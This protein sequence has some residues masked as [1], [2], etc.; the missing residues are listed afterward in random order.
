MASAGGF[1]EALDT[2]EDASEIEDPTAQRLRSYLDRLNRVAT[3]A[4]LRSL[5]TN[6]PTIDFHRLNSPLFDGLYALIHLKLPGNPTEKK[7]VEEKKPTEEKPM[8]SPEPVPQ[9]KKA[10]TEAER[11]DARREKREADIGK[12]PP[13]T[14][15]MAGLVLLKVLRESPTP[16]KY[17]PALEYLLSKN[18]SSAS[19]GSELY[20]QYLRVAYYSPTLFEHL[21]TKHIK[22]CDEATVRFVLCYSSYTVFQIAT[23][24]IIDTTAVFSWLLQARP[25]SCPDWLPKVEIALK[26]G[27]PYELEPLSVRI[28]QYPLEF[29]Q[30]LFGAVHNPKIPGT[31]P[32][33]LDPNTEGLLARICGSLNFEVIKLFIAQGAQVHTTPSEDSEFSTPL[34]ELFTEGYP[35]DNPEARQKMTSIRFEIAKF[36]LDHGANVHDSDDLPLFE[37]ALQR[38][39]ELVRFLLERGANI[40]ARQDRLLED[41]ISE[42]FLDDP[43]SPWIST[44]I[45]LGAV[46][47]P[48]ALFL[49]VRAALAF[50]EKDPL[51]EVTGAE[52]KSTTAPVTGLELLELLIDHR[53][54]VL[55]LSLFLDQ[56]GETLNEDVSQD[57]VIKVV[58]LLLQKGANLNRGSGLFLRDTACHRLTQVVAFLVEKGSRTDW[59]YQGLSLIKYVSFFLAGKETMTAPLRLLGFQ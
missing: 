5:I 48:E 34:A 30:L 39:L 4:E 8:A 13:T 2:S 3:F 45:D 29:W 12:Y 57:R 11:L 23:P 54:P 38:D 41:T 46:V 55:D 32:K 40:H 44:L 21:L 22:V 1:L 33:P 25:E 53:S 19:S 42:N 20:Q 6:I 59:T 51:P 9:K 28:Q 52:V 43:L 10:R 50:E 7:P 26:A 35:P 18:L 36:L 49:G 27:F 14:F 15:V 37:A 58:Q 17:L 16:E 47:T 56:V 31:L 24:F